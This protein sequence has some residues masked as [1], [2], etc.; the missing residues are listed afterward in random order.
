MIV[1]ANTPV[2]TIV[3][4]A[5]GTLSIQEFYPGTYT[6]KVYADH[7]FSIDTTIDVDTQ[8]NELLFEMTS[9]DVI[10]F[11]DGE[12]HLHFRNEG[13]RQWQ[14][15]EEVSYQGDYS[16]ASPELP[17][18]QYAMTSIDLYFETDVFMTLSTRVSLDSI[19]QGM[20]FTVDE[21]VYK[22]YYGIEDWKRDT[23]YIPQGIHHFQWSTSVGF[24]SP[25]PLY[26]NHCWIDMIEFHHITTVIPEEA[27]DKEDL[28]TCYPNPSGSM[29][30]GKFLQ[31]PGKVYHAGIYDNTGKLIR[32][33]E[34]TEMK[35]DQIIWDGMISGRSAAKGVYFLKVVADGG[36]EVEKLIKK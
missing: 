23:F 13:N 17:W 9:F 21:H 36:M 7:F 14:L 29:F 22:T 26:E 35:S 28:F 34:P 10:D 16:F 20:V 18:R 5:S 33:L 2:D 1:I 3:T 31:E 32:I 11:E 6:F 19:T 24:Q 15:D 4:D 25:S 12:D 30:Y 8:S 27:I